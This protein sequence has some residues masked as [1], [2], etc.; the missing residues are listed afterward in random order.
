MKEKFYRLYLKWF[1]K[2]AY[3]ALLECDRLKRE[4]AKAKRWHRSTRSLER[5][6]YEVRAIYERLT[7]CVKNKRK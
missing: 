7:T 6:F 5:Q 1:N 2:A 4:I 3:G